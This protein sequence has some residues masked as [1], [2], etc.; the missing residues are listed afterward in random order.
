VNRRMLSTNETKLIVA[1]KNT[2]VAK[3]ALSY[4]QWPLMPR[5]VPLPLYVSYLQLF[6]L[7][8]QFMFQNLKRLSYPGHKSDIDDTS[9]ISRAQKGT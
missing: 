8:R 9:P 7:I 4:F 2:L 5:T 3:N 6:A 1:K